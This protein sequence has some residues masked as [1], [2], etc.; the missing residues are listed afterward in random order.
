MLETLYRMLGQPQKRTVTHSGEVP[1]IG[2][3][4]W[5]CGCRLNY[6]DTQDSG[7]TKEPMLLQLTLCD[8]HSSEDQDE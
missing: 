5:K 7:V 1:W 8:L 2:R 4:I 3:M 6:M